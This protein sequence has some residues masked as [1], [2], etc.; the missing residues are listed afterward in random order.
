MH[1]SIFKTILKN[2]FG[3]NSWA[4]FE[5]IVNT[6]LDIPEFPKVGWLGLEAL[7]KYALECEYLIKTPS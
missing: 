5:Q 3:A 1:E 6:A 4:Q 2:E 7:F